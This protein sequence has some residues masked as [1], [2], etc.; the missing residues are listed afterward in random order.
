M[1]MVVVVMVWWWE[2]SKVTVEVVMGGTGDFGGGGCDG[3]SGNSN[4]DG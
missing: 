2:W 4:G 1:L 3:A